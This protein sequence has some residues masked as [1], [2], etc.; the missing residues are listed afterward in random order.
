[1]VARWDPE[2]WMDWKWEEEHF[3]EQVDT[4]RVYWYD[5]KGLKRGIGAALRKGHIMGEPSFMINI[6][7]FTGSAAEV[8]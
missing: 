6:E 3:W 8:R 7:R 1:M 5:N 2:P 4:V